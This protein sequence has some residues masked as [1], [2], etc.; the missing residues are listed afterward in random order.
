MCGFPG[1]G[2][3]GGAKVRQAAPLRGRAARAG[4]RAL[5]GT[6]SAGHREAASRH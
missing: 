1:H 2:E 5:D 6:D 4:R 3:I